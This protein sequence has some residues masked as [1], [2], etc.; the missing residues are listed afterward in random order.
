MSKLNGE[1]LLHVVY[2]NKD[3]SDIPDRKS[4]NSC[5]ILLK[6]GT[7]V[8]QKR[9]SLSNIETI[10][11]TSLFNVSCFRGE[12]RLG[13]RVSIVSVRMPLVVKQCII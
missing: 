8:D 11:V 5:P 6:F 7:H 10:G 12:T 9:L 3:V 1:Y 13:I 2:A 4:F